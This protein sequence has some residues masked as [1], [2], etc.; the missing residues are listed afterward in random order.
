MV[1]QLRGPPEVTG[2][3]DYPDDLDHR[4]DDISSSI[5]TSILKQRWNELSS[6]LFSDEIRFRIYDFREREGDE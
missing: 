2:Y 6:T 5:S 1:A 4:S 3:R